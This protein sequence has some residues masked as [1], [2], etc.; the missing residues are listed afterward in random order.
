MGRLLSA[1]VVSLTLFAGRPTAQGGAPQALHRFA[2]GQTPYAPTGIVSAPDGAALVVGQRGISMPPL[3]ARVTATGA[4][5]VLATFESYDTP[6]RLVRGGDG[7]YYSVTCSDGPFRHGTV[8]AI[9]ANGRLDVAYA[10][11]GEHDGQCPVDLLAGPD[12]T[13]HGHAYSA[14]STADR[15][16]FTIDTAGVVTP[17]TFSITGSAQPTAV[18]PDGSLYMFFAGSGLARRAPSGEVTTLVSS[19]AGFWAVLPMRDGTILALTSQAESVDSRCEL[20]RIASGVVTSLHSFSEACWTG[21]SRFHSLK[22]DTDPDS[23]FGFTSRTAFRVGPTGA[24]TV[25][26]RPA[27]SPTATIVDL[28]RLADGALWGVTTGGRFGGG[29]VFRMPPSGAWTTVATLP[30]GN[31]EGAGPVGPLVADA[32]GYLYG[33]ASVGGLYDRGTIFRVS[34]DGRRFETLYTFTGGSD[35]GFPNAL[36]RDRDGALYGTTSYGSDHFGTI[37]RVSRSGALTTLFVFRRH[38]DG[39][40]PGA[41]VVGADGAL[42]GRTSAGP[43]LGWGTAF[44]WSHDGF[45]TLHQFSAAD[46]LNGWLRDNSPFLSGADGN[47]YALTKSCTPFD[48]GLG[49]SVFRM[50]LRG[51]VTPLWSTPYD[52]SGPLVQ[53]PDGRLWGAGGFEGR[54]FVVLPTG[55]G[56]LIESDLDI[57]VAA[58][59]SDGA[60]Y[61]FAAE[62][63]NGRKADVSVAKI[64]PTGEVR[65]YPSGGVFRQLYRSSGTLIDGRDSFLYGTFQSSVPPSELGVVFRLSGPGPNAP[66]NVRIVR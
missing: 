52:F 21:W 1:L 35:G 37:F 2:W 49:T 5:S 11:R 39:G 19:D 65:R 58:A 38:E 22:V 31:R 44:R 45:S 25:L 16:F 34:K 20:V 43:G 8:V 17:A 46:R 56:R 55:G 28:D 42:Y 9:N 48:C 14:F 47:L 61:G 40:G 15:V 29:T 32:D 24:V 12:G 51:E 60:L 10:F 54:I 13:L 30:A 26:P 3:V 23:S 63:N 53:T 41:L 50:T 62:R 57:H 7:R 66:S 27:D 64:L 59:S 6:K 4:V 18:G 33:T 36:V